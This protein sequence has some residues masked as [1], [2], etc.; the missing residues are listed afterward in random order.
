M[1]KHG[2]PQVENIWDD[3]T[4]R[5][6]EQMEAHPRRYRDIQTGEN[7]LVHDEFGGE[8][9]GIVMKHSPLEIT[10]RY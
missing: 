5:V 9:S 7:I 8:H 3:L 2:I 4:S 1:G 10:W 6:R